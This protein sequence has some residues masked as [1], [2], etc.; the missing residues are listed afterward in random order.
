VQRLGLNPRPPVTSPTPSPQ[1]QQATEEKAY[2]TYIAPQAATA[3]AVALYDT[4]YNGS[5]AYKL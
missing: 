5:A 4:G 1:R 2:N 3:A